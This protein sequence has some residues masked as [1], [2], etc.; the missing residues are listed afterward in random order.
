MTVIPTVQFLTTVFQEIRV[1]FFPCEYF[2]RN[3]IHF[4]LLLT[5]FY[6]LTITVDHFFEISVVGWN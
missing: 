4:S 6:V 3:H 1:L 2:T 5:V